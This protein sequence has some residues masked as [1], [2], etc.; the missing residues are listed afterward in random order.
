MGSR[1]DESKVDNHSNIVS[2][3][4]KMCAIDLIIT[5]THNLCNQELLYVR[6][7]F[8]NRNISPPQLT[9]KYK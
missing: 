9:Y 1:G 8:S 3:I 7:V 6:L 5:I 4:L 2:D